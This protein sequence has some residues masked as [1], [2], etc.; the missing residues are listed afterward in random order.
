[1]S[2]G[3]S[4]V[5]RRDRLRVGGGA[6]RAEDKQGTPAQSHI[7]PSVLVFTEKLTYWNKLSHLLLKGRSLAGGS[8]GGRDK[9]GAPMRHGSGEKTAGC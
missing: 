7:S 8:S 9:S 4:Q 3:S 1:M 5:S 6:A 2:P